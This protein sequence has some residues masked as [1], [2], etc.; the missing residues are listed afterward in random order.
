MNANNSI[1]KI[2]EKSLLL[3]LL[4]SIICFISIDGFSQKQSSEK[5]RMID[6]EKWQKITKAK[7]YH[8]KELR[9]DPVPFPPPIEPPI[10]KIS[11]PLQI[12]FYF[13]IIIMLAFLIFWLVSGK[14]HKTRQKMDKSIS[15]YSSNEIEI[16]IEQAHLERLLQSAIDEKQYYLAVRIQ[17]I[18]LIRFLNDINLVH[19]KIDK[20]NRDYLNE[21]IKSEYFYDFRKLS[22]IYEKV[23]FGSLSVSENDYMAINTMFNGFSQRLKNHEK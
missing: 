4:L 14:I 8:E 15:V 3:V 10:T 17:F 1:H 19:Y 5:K 13:L 16:N 7:S 9:N 21:M 6:N 18:L 12:F 23:W 20:T 2:V 11:A 22:G